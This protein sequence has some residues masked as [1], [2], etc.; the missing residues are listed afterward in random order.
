VHEA[1]QRKRSALAALFYKFRGDSIDRGVSAEHGGL[2]PRLPRR[3]IEHPHTG[4]RQGGAARFILGHN[5]A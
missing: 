4:K 2:R 5:C 1:L 3:E